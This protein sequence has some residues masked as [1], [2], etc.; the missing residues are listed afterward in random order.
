[1]NLTTLTLPQLLDW[2]NHC[3]PE[4]LSLTQ[5]QNLITNPNTPYQILIILKA[6]IESRLT[7]IL[8]PDLEN[9]LTTLLHRLLNHQKLRNHIAMQTQLNQEEL[10][11]LPSD[12]I[13]ELL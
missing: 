6:I 13:N 9:A 10:N 11:S 3:V 4:E 1:M 2:W 12:W 8:L 7:R 5:I